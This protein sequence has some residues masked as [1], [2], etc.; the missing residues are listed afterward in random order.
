MNRISAAQLLISTGR[1]IQS[2]AV[3]VMR[4][5]DL[6]EFGRL[7]YSRKEAVRDFCSEQFVGQGL[8]I[9]ETELFRRITTSGGRILVLGAGGG[10]EALAF[11]GKGYEVTAVDFI[12]AMLSAL[13]D[14]ADRMGLQVNTLPAEITEYSAPAGTFDVIWLSSF[15]YSSIPTRQKRERFLKK[16]NACLTED[17]A[18][19]CQ[20]AWNP[21]KHSKPLQHRLRRIFAILTWGNTL[22]QPGDSLWLNKEFLHFF[23]SVRDIQMEF[24]AGGFSIVWHHK[25]EPPGTNAEFLLQKC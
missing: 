19:A 3:P 14:H 21:A 10:R 15:M 9:Q 20:V 12:P 1:F 11:A 4:P 24:K 25:P 22:Y 16:M 8:S 18:F 23:G 2:L 13:N 6:V 7:G 17:G 5:T